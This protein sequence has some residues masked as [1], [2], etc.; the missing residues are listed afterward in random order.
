MWLNIF[1]IFM[2]T[3]ELILSSIGMD[4]YFGS[5]FFWLDL[6][7]TLSIVTDIEPVWNAII[8]GDDPDR[9]LHEIED[10]AKPGQLNYIIATAQ[11]N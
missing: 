6:V 9:F 7:S 5:F 1:A 2:F 11:E 10:K 8:G 4:D 3:I